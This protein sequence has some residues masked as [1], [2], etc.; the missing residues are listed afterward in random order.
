MSMVDDVLGELAGSID[1]SMK[2]LKV[3]LAKLRT[4]RANLA[5]LD[6]VRVEYYGTPTPLNQCANLAVADAR[7][8]TVRPWDKNL[9][10]DIEKA[11]QSA[12]IGITPQS[13]GDIIRLP[14]PP[15]TEERRKDLVKHAKQ[16]GEEARISV[17]NHR[18][19]A[20]DMLKELEK[21]KEISQDD[22]KRALEKVQEATDKGVASVD[23]IIAA[24]EK[25]ILEI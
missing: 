7:L 6:D 11:I 18:R 15:L 16:R 4:G 19:D 20:N 9:I 2:S 14:V 13:D 21:E 23:D 1:G 17:R 3:N 24:K 10:G 25:E 5:L 22:L 12:D 8:I